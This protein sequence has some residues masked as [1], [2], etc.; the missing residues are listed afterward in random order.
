MEA[1]NFPVELVVASAQVSHKS[2]KFGQR[3]GGFVA[4]WPWP[5]SGSE[6]P[7]PL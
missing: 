3:D 1:A 5:L 6:W 2:G 7:W 4:V